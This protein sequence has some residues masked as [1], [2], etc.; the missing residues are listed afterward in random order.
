MKIDNMCKSIKS[1]EVDEQFLD[2]YQRR[3]IRRQ[4]GVNE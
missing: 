1:E 3:G 4:G 2:D